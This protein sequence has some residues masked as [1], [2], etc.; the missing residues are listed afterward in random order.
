MT[1]PNNASAPLSDSRIIEF[2]ISPELNSEILSHLDLTI[3]FVR[4]FLRS[5]SNLNL[6]LNTVFS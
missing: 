1:R 2:D 3:D 6:D 4:L 5:L